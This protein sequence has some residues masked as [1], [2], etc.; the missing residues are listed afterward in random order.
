VRN[1][2]LLTLLLL[3]PLVAHAE[4]APPSEG[5]AA[6]GPAAQAPADATAETP[7]EPTTTAARLTA[8]QKTLKELQKALQDLDKR[9]EDL[10]KAMEREER[11]EEARP[12]RKKA[13][14]PEP[15]KKDGEEGAEKKDG[16][17]SEEEAPSDEGEKPAA[18]GEDGA[19]K[20]EGEDEGEPGIDPAILEVAGTY[21]VDIDALVEAMV[22][23][24][25]E[26]SGGELPQEFLDMFVEQFRTQ[27]EESD[28]AFVFET[29]LTWKVAGTMAGETQDAGGT[30]SREG[31]ELTLLQTYENG[32]E[33]D[34]PDTMTGTFE[35]GVI[36]LVPDD[37]AGVPFA[38]VLRKQE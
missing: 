20:K 13:K 19:E 22:A 18:E 33:K 3:F 17:A 34:E 7:A 6:E 37:E 25:Q 1:A 29:D 4:E 5:A 28:L 12:A 15:K 23:A 2:L 14:K 10:E 26:E 16:E 27:L 9:L 11:G 21:T 32:E 24:M 35:D 38:I 31:N 36:E 30:W 8:L